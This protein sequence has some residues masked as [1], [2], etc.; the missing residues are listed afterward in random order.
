MLEIVCAFTPQGERVF[1]PIGIKAHGRT[2]DHEDVYKQLKS[3]TFLLFFSKQYLSCLTWKIIFRGIR[4][5]A[6]N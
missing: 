2:K 4:I 3:V 1:L 5:F 6:V